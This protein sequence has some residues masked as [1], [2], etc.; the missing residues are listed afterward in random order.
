[1]RYILFIIAII[2]IGFIQAKSNNIDELPIGLTE[3]EKNN[4]NIIYEMGRETDPPIA[5]IRN[6]AEFERMSGALIRYPLGISLE[7]VRE[8][9]ED[10]KVYCLVSSSQQNNAI[11]SFENANVN[12]N[13]VEFI[14]GSTDSYWTRDYGPWWV[15]DG[16]GD[17]SVVDFTYNRPRPNDNDAPFKV[18]EYLNVPYYSTNLVHCGGNYMTDGLGTASSSDLVYSENDETDQQINDLM[19]SYYGIDTYHVLPDPNN[20]YIDH[21]DC[22]GKYLSPTKVLIREVPQNHP[23]YNEIEYVASYFSESLTEWGYPWEVHRVYTPNDQPYTNS[24]ILN[25]KVLVPIMN[26]SWDDDAINAYELA[27]PGYEIIGVT[28]SW[29]STDALHCRVKG[30]PDLDMLQLFHNPLRDTVDSFIN[31][32]YMINA[33]IDDLSKTGIVDGSVKVFWKTEAEFEYDSTDLH[34][35]LVPEEPNTYTGY[36]PSQ[37][38]GSEINYFIQALDSSGRKEK[39]PMAGYHSFFALPTD[40]CN[41]WSL[42]DVDNSGELNIIDVILLSELIVYGNSLGMCCDFVADINEDGELSII[43]IVNLVSMVVNQ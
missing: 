39:H 36:L 42:G 34:L 23:Q 37:L 20:T 40:I 3:H 10:I 41:S 30:I 16:S 33:V 19:E 32:G 6:I 25:E 17:V 24:L 22:W 28:G 8:L 26:S 2:N 11:N 9:A 4:I 43:D 15:V 35:S 13:N 18:S 1:M 5:P 27:M 12:M 7:I 31:E 29:E 21:I 14:L 38:Y